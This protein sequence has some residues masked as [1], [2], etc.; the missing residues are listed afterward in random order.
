MI[1]NVKLRMMML[2]L[3]HLTWIRLLALILR[4]QDSNDE[5][6][7]YLLKRRKSRRRARRT[8]AMTRVSFIIG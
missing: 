7:L 6:L 4:R 3:P 8:V 1:V 2:L 5:E